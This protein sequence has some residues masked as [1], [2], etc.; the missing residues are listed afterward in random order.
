MGSFKF[1]VGHAGAIA[2]KNKSKRDACSTGGFIEAPTSGQTVDTSNPVTLAWDSSCL[3]ITAADIYL[4][5]PYKD[6]SLIQMFHNVDFSKGSY[7]TTL[8]P[9]WWNSTSSVDLQVTIVDSGSPAFLATL[10]A[11]PIWTANYNASAANSDSSD[12]GTTSSSDTNITQVDNLESKSGGLSKGAIAAAVIFPLIALGIGLAIY[13][14]LTRTR[15]EKR[16]KRWSEAMDKRMSVISGDW[17]SLSAKGA[18]AAI[19]ASFAGPNRSSVWSGPGSAGVGIPRPSSTIAVEGALSEGNPA[20]PEMAQ[21]RTT[22]VGLRGPIPSA[23]GT[24]RVSRVSFAADTHFSRASTGDNLSSRGR[25]SADSRRTGV[26]SRA[27][28][29]AYIPPVPLPLRQSEY[30][31]DAEASAG[32]DSEEVGSGMMSPTQ[33][34]GPVDL[35]VD[36]IRAR[37]E[38]DG[39]PRHSLDEMMPALNMMRTM[40]GSQ[41]ELVERVE[42]QPAPIQ[43]PIAVPTPPPAAKSPIIDAIQMQPVP[44]GAMSPDEMLRAYAERRRTGASIVSPP[45][46]PNPVIAFPMPVASTGMMPSASSN[47]MRTLYS[48]TGG[49]MDSAAVATTPTGSEGSNNPFRKSMAHPSTDMHYNDEDAYF[50]AS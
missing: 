7:N 43:M 19:R 36:D 13:V 29:S 3:N 35:S 5:A 38:N 40:N 4:Y 50:G 33:R 1:R 28:H 6:S 26:P 15:E 32:S 8:K 39:A 2:H 46:T 14:R 10:P 22:G 18:E 47:T 17:R 20:P 11:G 37:M 42:Q 24:T 12:I 49:S 48:P 9:K 30:V 16:R 23:A 21:I 45:G 25:P 34:E 41:A 27:F 31:A 44:T